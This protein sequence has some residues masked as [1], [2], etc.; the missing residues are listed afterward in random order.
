MKFEG[1]K[2]Q[3]T[4]NMDIKEIAKLVRKEIKAKFPTIK[5]SVTIDR[6]SMGQ[7]LDVRILEVPFQVVNPEHVKECF[8]ADGSYNN[9]STPRASRLTEAG[10]NLIETIEGIV[11][12]YNFDDSDTQTDYFH[13]RFYSSTQLAHSLEESQRKAVLS[14]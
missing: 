5:T 10:K 12:Q 4:K 1:S 8:N 9:M 6:Y 2:L 7:S 14:A 13:K 3:E 11:N